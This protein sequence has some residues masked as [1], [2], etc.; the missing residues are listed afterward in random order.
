MNGK[1]SVFEE[2]IEK[3]QD[4]LIEDLRKCIRFPSVSEINDGEF[5]FGKQVHNCLKYMLELAAS[6][7]FKTCNVDNHAGWCE[8]GEGDEMI[9][10]LGH[11]DVVPAGE[12]WSVLPYEGIV[13]DGKIYGR[14][15]MDDKGPTVAA[16]YSLLALKESGIRLDRRIRLIFG[17]SEE[18]GGNDIRYYLENG[19]EIPVMGFTPDGEYPVIHGEKGFIIEHY[20]YDFEK[21]AGEDI[22]GSDS[23]NGCWKIKKIQGGTAENIVPHYAKAVL[24]RTVRNEEYE[25]TEEFILTADGKNAHA[26]SPWDGENAIQKLLKKLAEIPLCSEQKEV[27]DFLHDKFKLECKGE[28]LGIAMEDAVSGPL[29]MNL[30]MI[31]GDENSIGLGMNY[32]YPVTRTFEECEPVLRN[33]FEEKGFILTEQEHDPCLYISRESELVKRLMKVYKEATGRNDEPKCI[34]GATYAKALPNVLAF[35][36]LFPDDENREHRPDEYVEIEWLKRNA[37]IIAE[38]MYALGTG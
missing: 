30:G 17:L 26:A 21:K 11:L 38:A 1:H 34:G 19:G 29:S 32:R 5:P 33:Q 18:N 23:D 28:S 20:K 13:Q 6:M 4:A 2:I 31:Y 7:G 16:L 15:T 14:G 37:V 22:H 8:Y 10:V 24:E 36:P 25:G 35:G 12:G 3:Y 27:I 9:A